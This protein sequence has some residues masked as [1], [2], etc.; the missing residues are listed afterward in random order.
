MATFYVQLEQAIADNKET[1]GHA[2]QKESK[3][4][5]KCGAATVIRRSRFGKLFHGCSN[6]PKCTGIINI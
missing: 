5:P 4:C 2:L 6:Y 1:M 3:T